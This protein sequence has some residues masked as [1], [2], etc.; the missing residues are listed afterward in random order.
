MTCFAAIK[1]AQGWDGT[2]LDC[3]E[4][5]LDVA[6]G[7]GDGMEQQAVPDEFSCEDDTCMYK[8]EQ[9]GG[10]YNTSSLCCDP[11][12]ECVVKNWFYAQCLPETLAGATPAPLPYA[13]TVCHFG[14]CHVHNLLSDTC[15]CHH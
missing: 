12:T 3:E 4:M 2:V 8:F 11:E 10:G 6:G 14:K 7:P 9:C 15:A 5:P 1:V 13:S